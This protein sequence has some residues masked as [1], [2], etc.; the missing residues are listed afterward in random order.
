MAKEDKEL[1]KGV[2]DFVRELDAAESRDS[3]PVAD[4]ELPKEVRKFI[5]SYG[6]SDEDREAAMMRLASD[7]ISKRNEAVTAREGSGIEQWWSYAEEAYN[8][9]DDANRDAA[10]A[11]GWYKPT[12][13]SG[14]LTMAGGEMGDDG[15][16]KSTVFVPLTARYVDAAAAKVHDILIDVDDK[17]FGL[18]STPIPDLVKAKEDTRT[19]GFPDGTPMTKPSEEQPIAQ[20]QPTM[21]AQQPT[22]APGAPIPQ[23]QPMGAPDEMMAA[24]GP[25]VEGD[26]RVAV[27]VA[28]LARENI[29]AADKAAK[30]AEDR[31]YDWLVE[32]GHAAEMR[33]VIFDAA[34]LGVGVLKGPHPK[35][36]H[37]MAVVRSE[38]PETGE[39]EITLE[40]RSAMVPITERVSPWAVY[41][42]PACGEKIENGSYVWERDYYSPSKVKSLRGQPGFSDRLVDMVLEIGVEGMSPQSGTKQPHYDD[43]YDERYKG[44]YEV[45]H[46]VGPIRKSDYDYLHGRVYNDEPYS[47]DN[48]L[49]E[50]VNVVATMIADI[51]VKVVRSHFEESGRLL[52]Y[53]FPWRRRTGLWAGCGV[54]EQVMTA[55]KIV[56]GGTRALLDNA[57]LSAGGQI[58]M[59]RDAIEP[60]D[61]SDVITGMKLWYLTKDALND[62]VKRAFNVYQFPNVT[63]QLMQVIMYGQQLAEE[64]SSVPLISQGQ[65]GPT[66]P[67]TYGATQLQNSNANQLLRSIGFSADDYITRPLIKAMYEWLLLDPNVPDY[68]K[69]DFQIHAAGSSALVERAIQDQF[70][71]Q[72][73]GQSMNP[74]FGLDPKKLMTEVLRSRH[75]RPSSVQMTEEQQMRMDAMMQPPPPEP[76]PRIQVEQIRM[77]MKQMELQLEQAE[78]QAKMQMKQQELGFNVQAKQADIALK[79]QAMQ[80]D[81]QSDEMDR[82]VAMDTA[83][84]QA[85]VELE[86]TKIAALREG[87]N[88]AKIKQSAEFRIMNMQKQIEMKQMDYA[89]RHQISMDQAK[90]RLADTAMRLKQQERLSMRATAAKNGASTPETSVPP[91][92]PLGLA[93]VGR[94]YEQ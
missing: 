55:Q 12:D 33:S 13:M 30:S 18:V 52:Y 61:R 40:K 14:P 83:V 71:V 19:V 87:S 47:D 72:L 69:G 75:L 70:I 5:R 92:E 43:S 38:D 90:T 4:L 62:D 64:S 88:Q 17:P 78:I 34:R 24:A 6:A 59:D 23:G 2:K 16:I 53:N 85:Q 28:D 80:V 86:K 94:S 48:P 41:P 73:L 74:A 7:L 37:D 91:T 89:N 25:P 51:P 50:T 21:P 9:V 39:E 68:E 56:N 77:Q 27:T 54:G 15:T 3:I 58:V 44:Q 31:I 67:E 29:D 36:K 35:T 84:L 45:W 60:A 82:Q 11:A 49:E 65:T 32:C 42:D 20:G 1:P 10:N 22:L 26:G 93:E 57:G 63:N 46:Y 76:D 79:Q 81:Y 8:S 66:T